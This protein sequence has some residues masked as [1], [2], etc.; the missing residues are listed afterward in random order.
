MPAIVLEKPKLSRPMWNSLKSHIIR[1]R[2]RKKQEQE[3]DAEVERQRREREDQQKEQEMTLEETKEQVAQSESRLSQLKEDKHQLFLQLKKVLNEDDTRRKI[4]ESSF[5]DMM[6]FHPYPSGAPLVHPSTHGSVYMHPNLGASRPVFNGGKE[7]S[8]LNLQGV[9]PSSLY[10]QAINMVPSLGHQSQTNQKRPRSPS[11]PPPQ[12]YH[13]YKPPA[14]S[15]YNSKS[16]GSPYGGSPAVPG[17]IFY[18]HSVSVSAAHS[19]A[20]AGYQLP[21]GSMYSYPNHSGSSRP[22]YS[23]QTPAS[24]KDDGKHHATVYVGQGNVLSQNA[25]RSIPTRNSGP[26][27]NQ[28]YHQPIEHMINKNSNAYGTTEQEKIFISPSLG[29]SPNVSTNV[30]SVSAGGLRP[31][32]GL[33]TPISL[34]GA[35]HPSGIPIQQQNHASKSGSIITGNPL[36]PPTSAGYHSAIP[37]SNAQNNRLVNTQSGG[38][39]CHPTRY[40]GNSS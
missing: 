13:S 17:S 8:I 28:G 6:L 19:A 29:S 23:V 18:T 15:P 34:P 7:E 4:K 37:A 3:A 27:L 26:S 21:P 32:T 12:L 5:N 30:N 39:T 24:S 22:T 10:G 9:P 20:S 11:P 25:Q 33:L 16:I 31:H 38:Q 1:E 40:Y 35:S 2:Q 14:L 36:R